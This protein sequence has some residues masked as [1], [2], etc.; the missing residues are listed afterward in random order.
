MQNRKL[1]HAQTFL[2]TNT[3]GE[4]V[5]EDEPSSHYISYQLRDSRAMKDPLNLGVKT[6]TEDQV[7]EV[8]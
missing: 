7:D 6:N 2:I 8:I 4:L 3:K 1:K 5:C